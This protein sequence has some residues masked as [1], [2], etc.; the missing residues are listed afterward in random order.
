MK[1]KLEKSLLLLIILIMLVI[2]I[3]LIATVAGN[4]FSFSAFKSKI[5]I[6]K[7]DTVKLEKEEEEPH[8]GQV[9]VWDG[10]SWIW[11]TPYKDMP[12]NTLTEEDFNADVSYPVYTGDEYTT[13]RGID[14]SEWQTTKDGKEFLIDWQ[15]V[16]RENLDFVFIRCGRRGYTEGGLFRDEYFTYNIQNA[17]ANGMKCGVYFFSQAVNESEAIE[18]AEY[19]LDI[20]KDYDITY[21]IMFDWERQDGVDGARTADLNPAIVNDCAL[22]FCRTIEAAGYEAGIYFNQYMGYHYFNLPEFK[23]FDLWVADP[24]AVQSFYYHCDYWQCTFDATVAGIEGV[25]DMNLLFV[26]KE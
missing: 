16:A 3:I 10:L 24:D 9:Y 6:D 18:E 2:A 21:P 19:V 4:A 20:I 17:L 13:L 1:T 12:A 22:A 23:D 25:V 15:Q 8:K 11:I 7:R 26:P 14:V 5:N